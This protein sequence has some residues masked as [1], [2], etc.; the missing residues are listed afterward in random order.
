MEKEKI[1]C[2]KCNKNKDFDCFYK[3]SNRKNGLGC[4]CKSCVGLYQVKNKEKLKEYRKEYYKKNKEKIIKWQ[5]EYRNLEENNVKILKYKKKYY[6]ENKEKSLSS[7]KKWHKENN[8]KRNAIAAK[9]R[10]NKKNQTPEMSEE[11]WENINDIYK[12]CSEL[13]E[14]TGVP[15]EVDHIIP[16]S[17]GGLHHPDNLQILTRSKNRSKKD[18]L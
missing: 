13:S 9:Y 8:Y 4:Y 16:I 14:E 5:L 12:K 3:N 6:K 2:G 11:E 1:R 10:A 15:Y 18:K 7:I 17:K